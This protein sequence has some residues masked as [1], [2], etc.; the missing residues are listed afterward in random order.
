MLQRHTEDLLTQVF[1]KE[2]R[3]FRV[4][5]IRLMFELGIQYFPSV[6]MLLDPWLHLNDVIVEYDHDGTD[7]GIEWH[8]MNTI[9]TFVTLAA[10]YGLSGDILGENGVD[11]QTKS[12]V[13]SDH[14]RASIPERADREAIGEA[15]KT[16]MKH[17]G[18]P[19]GTYTPEVEGFNG[20]DRR[21]D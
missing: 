9:K 6:H 3:S 17:Q 12:R 14:C 1:R 2:V 4:I 5:R 15:W 8:S 10:R 18:H 20:Y 16:L 11:M 7:P 21:Y 13:Y 19:S